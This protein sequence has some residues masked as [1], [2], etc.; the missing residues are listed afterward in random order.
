VSE[1]GAALPSLNGLGVGGADAGHFNA[2]VPF[3]YAL[4]KFG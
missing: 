3:A 1:E 2:N 4:F